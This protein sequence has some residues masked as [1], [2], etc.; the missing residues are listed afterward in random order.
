VYPVDPESG[1]VEMGRVRAVGLTVILV[2]ALLGAAG[3][4]VDGGPRTKELESLKASTVQII[5]DG[6]AAGSGV[7]IGKRLVLTAAHVVENE[8]S[9][10]LRVRQVIDG[11]EYSVRAGLERFHES[12]DM[13]WLKLEAD[14]GV[15][16]D[17]YKGDLDFGQEIV[18]TGAPLLHG[19]M[20][21]RG[22][23][24]GEPDA[25]IEAH[26]PGVETMEAC[27]HLGMS[28]GPVWVQVGRRWK[29]AGILVLRSV[30]YCN[31]CWM[32]PLSE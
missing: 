6:N 28:G 10:E 13:A 27:T 19:I 24:A 18:I 30:D 31:V 15:V 29:V 26:Y 14:I 22:S 20:A 9:A 12:A 16:A 4:G 1:G 8:P 21:V 11:Q 23:S 3:I 25:W 32:Q 2:W 17:T 7:V 5:V